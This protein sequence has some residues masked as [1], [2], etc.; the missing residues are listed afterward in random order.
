MFGSFGMPELVVLLVIGLF[1]GVPI[2]AAIWALITLNS[3]R[4]GQQAIDVRLAT[5]E[6]L[7]QG[8]Q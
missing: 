2:V 5:I 1:W 3:I 8:R 7:L 6:R 4:T